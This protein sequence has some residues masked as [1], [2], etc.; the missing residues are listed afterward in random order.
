MEPDTQNIDLEDYN[1]WELQRNPNQKK[2]EE[3]PQEKPAESDEMD[4]DMEE[5]DKGDQF[6]AVLPWLGA[7]V[8][9]SNP[10]KNNPTPPSKSLEPEYVWGYRCGDCRDNVFY[11]SEENNIV[12]MTAAIGVVLDFTLNKQKFFGCGDK[13]LNE[14]AHND[15]ITALAIHPNRDLVATGQVG[16]DPLICIWSTKTM[17]LVTSFKQGRDTRAVRSLG[18][19]K[20]GKYLASTGDDNEH[21]VFVYDVEKSSKICAEKSGPDPIID[22]DFSTTDDETFVTA[23]KNGVKFWNFKHPKNFEYKKGVFASHKMC[24]MTSVQYLNDG[25]VVSGSVLGDL[26]VWQAQAC[27]K[28]LKAHSKPITAISCSDSG[29]LVTGSADKTLNIYDKSLAVVKTIQVGSNPVG[30]DQDDKG[31]ILVGLRNGTVVQWT[32]DVIKTLM[33]S[34]S[35][36]EV[37][38]LTIDP[39]AGFVLTTAD[40]NRVLVFDPKKNLC[41]VTKGVLNEKKGPKPKIGGAS[42]LSQYPPNQCSRAVAISNK[43]GNIIIAMNDGTVSVRENLFK[44]NTEIAAINDAK[45]W[46][47]IISFSPDEKRVAIG[48]HDNNIYVYDTSSYKLISIC[49]GH[50]SYITSVDW[51]SNGEILFSTCGAYEMLYFDAESGKHIAAGGSAFKD[52]EFFTFSNKLGWIVQGIFPSG[53][54]GTHINGID[55]SKAKDLIATSDDW[56]LVNLYRNPCLKGNKGKS[57]VGHSEHVVR[58]KFDEKDEYVYSVGGYDQ[59]LIKW[60]VVSGV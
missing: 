37:W 41:V 48:S 43:T 3:Q 10:P 36:G 22:Q 56:G 5:A 16:K 57:Y 17:A 20:K 50:N 1:P 53:T 31:S 39:K 35:D 58:A 46:C 42:T 51:S 29:I 38:G 44:I 27:M 30:I 34:H 19:S 23:G 47:E 28:V 45:E 25:R 4:F 21:T 40:D 14:N 2:K 13:D 32:D 6:M 33:V 49:K 15:D 55:R 54:D 24:D 12:Y 9:P 59:T 52:E 60:K 7:L 8:P 18:W 26:Y 11:T